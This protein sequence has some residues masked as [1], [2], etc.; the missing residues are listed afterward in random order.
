MLPRKNRMNRSKRSPQLKR[1]ALLT[2]LGGVAVG[3]PFLEA[4]APR[5]VRA[6]EGAAPKRLIIVYTSNGTVLRDW[7]PTTTGPD[8]TVPRILKPFDTELLRPKLSVVSGVQM[9][10]A[11]IGSANGH[12]AGMTSLLTGR[13]FGEAEATEFGTVGWGAG[14]SI[15]QEIAKHVAAPGQLPSLQAGVQTQRQY[16]NFYSYLSYGEGGGSANAIA[17]EDDPKKVFNRLFANIPSAEQTEAELQRRVDQRKSVLD[18]VRG[19]FAQ[20][21]G[22]LGKVDNERLEKHASLI[23]DLEKRIVVEPFCA[24]PESPT[25][26]DGRIHKNEEFI[27]ITRNQID[28]IATALSCDMTRVATLQLSTAQSGVNYKSLLE[29]TDTWDQPGDSSHHSLSHDAVPSDG[30]GEASGPQAAAVDKMSQV[31]TWFA[32]QIA[33]LAERLAL[34]EEEDGSTLLDNTAILWVSEVSEGPSHK[35]DDMPF[36]LLGDLQ[37][38]LKTGHFAFGNEETHNNLYVT[39]GKAMGLENFDV[40]GDPEFCTG[41]IDSLLA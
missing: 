15:D 32:S 30:L 41:A 31:N 9:A 16:G 40:F 10:S 33:Y 20:L 13:P 3:L 26:E 36:V 27:E 24:R 2:G 12:A 1:R 22:K 23:R 7:L 35:F 5:A 21:K 19:D 38:S 29:N 6:A 28:S 14:I 11:K 4:L 18:L 8:F 37:G 25:V 17:S 34:Y 39:L